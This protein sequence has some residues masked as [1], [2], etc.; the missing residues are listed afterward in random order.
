MVDMPKAL[1]VIIIGGLGYISDDSQSFVL[2]VVHIVP[3]LLPLC[4]LIRIPMYHEPQ[5]LFY[6]LLVSFSLPLARIVIFS[7]VL[8]NAILTEIEIS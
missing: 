3:F 6:F 4:G 1:T 2:F 5:F 8:I 7:E